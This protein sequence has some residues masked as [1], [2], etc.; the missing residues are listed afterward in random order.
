MHLGV[1]LIHMRPSWSC[2]LSEFKWTN[3]FLD[4]NVRITTTDLY[5]TAPRLMRCKLSLS[6]LAE[7]VLEFRGL[8]SQGAADSLGVGCRTAAYCKQT[9]RKFW[10]EP[11][12]GKLPGGL[13]TTFAALT[14]MQSYIL[15]DIYS[16]R[17]HNVLISLI[18]DL[19]GPWGPFKGI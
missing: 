12:C 8:S 9:P 11:N 18:I 10:L 14:C 4:G 2:S 16:T 13:C 15:K 1:P 3:L 7:K 5:Q 19:G 17:D 6:S